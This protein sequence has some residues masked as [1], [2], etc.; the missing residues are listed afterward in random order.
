MIVSSMQDIQEIYIR[1]QGKKKE[2]K[3][4]K[5]IIKEGMV[6]ST[7]LKEVKDQMEALRAKKKQLE[8]GIM[9]DYTH[10]RGDIEGIDQD[11]KGDQVMMDD[12]ALNLYM[13]GE[14][15]CIKDENEVE[16]EPIFK[17]KY[18]KVR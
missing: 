18:Q 17:V 16:F 5:N 2:R 14:S 9:A 3:R 10:E 6:A 15:I 4:I 13:K 7:P 12:I 11:I 1:I 8:E